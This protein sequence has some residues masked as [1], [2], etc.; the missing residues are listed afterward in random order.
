MT[1]KRWGHANGFSMVELMIG[2]GLVA[3]IALFASQF[4]TNFSKNRSDVQ[5]FVEQSSFG[6]Y[7]PR[8][9]KIAET[10]DLS[11][12]FLRLP[13]STSCTSLNMPCLKK[14][15]PTT[16]ESSSF[17]SSGLPKYFEFYKDKEAVF[18]PTK[19]NSF[20]NAA[21]FDAYY[22][23]NKNLLD[24]VMSS[25]VNEASVVWPLTSASSPEFPVLTRSVSDV[26]FSF[27]G[28]SASTTAQYGKYVLVN[29][30]S[31]DTSGLLSL[32]GSPVVVYNP[33]YPQQFI[34]QYLSEIV[35]CKTNI[36]ACKNAFTGN[37]AVLSAINQNSLIIILKE[38]DA[39]QYGNFAPNL[40]NYSPISLTSTGDWSYL[41]PTKTPNLKAAT[42]DSSSDLSSPIALA[43]WAHFY[44]ANSM[45]PSDLF[46]MPV[47]WSVY[48]LRS[49]PDKDQY[50]SLIRR[51]FN[52]LKNHI[53][54]TEISLIKGS[55]MFSRK[56]GTKTLR[57]S[58][59][60]EAE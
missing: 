17:S 48:F 40:K 6:A 60:G 4:G 44:H 11:S 19:A 56:I 54:T 10:A 46:I 27:V 28:A 2:V 38:I 59:Y 53:E 41:F 20:K 8:F 37:T 30:I 39:V 57:F 5:K 34:I 47:R 1:K 22:L 16:G 49:V 15:D 31:G 42:S 58:V 26:S 51:D 35:S 14:I 36:S 45:D 24:T 50:F 9:T 55:V 33:Y 32:I 3:L 29:Y 43:R 21:S 23:S 13:I 25:V 52:G 18:I 12:L 7:G